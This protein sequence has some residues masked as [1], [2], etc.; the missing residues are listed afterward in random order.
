MDIDTGRWLSFG[1]GKI[2]V[3]LPRE[4]AGRRQTILVVED[5]VAT[6]HYYRLVL[7]LAG[8]DVLE[9]GDGYDALAVL[10]THTPDLVVLDLG[11][12]RISGHVVRDDLAAQAHTRHI[13]VVI[14]TGELEAPNADCVLAKPITPER[15]VDVVRRCLATGAPPLSSR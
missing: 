2:S 5:D 4:V 9:V 12:P 13:P 3:K 15:L 6:R 1:D 8:F 10:E 14:I 11:L 7:N